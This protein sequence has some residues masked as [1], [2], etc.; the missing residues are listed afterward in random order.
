MKELDYIGGVLF[1]LSSTL[2]VIGIVC[3][4]IV[5]LIEQRYPFNY[6]LL[7]CLDFKQ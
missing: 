1:I 7:G 2:T 3:P 4:E 5:P 6:I